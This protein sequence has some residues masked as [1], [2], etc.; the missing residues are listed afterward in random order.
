MVSFFRNLA[1]IIILAGALLLVLSFFLN[2]SIWFGIELIK[3]GF[4][5]FLL[6]L[7]IQVLE[8]HYSKRGTEKLVSNT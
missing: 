5:L 6:G 7:F 8:P 3:G 1:A 4:F 2:L